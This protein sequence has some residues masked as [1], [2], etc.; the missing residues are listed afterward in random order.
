MDSAGNVYVAE[1]NNHTIRKITPAGLVSTLAGAAGLAN[2]TDGAGAA[3]RFSSPVGVAVDSAGNVYV[4]DAGNNTIRK[5]NSGGVVSTLAGAAR[6]AGI[7]DGP[8]TAARFNGPSSVAVDSAGNLYVADLSNHTLR[9]VTPGGVRV[10]AGSGAFMQANFVTHISP[11]PAGEF[12]QTVSF[13]VGND[14]N[15]FFSVQPA[16]AANGT[17]T[18]TP[19]A[20]KTGTATVTVTAVDSGPGTA[21]SVNTSAP[22]TFLI[23]VAPNAAPSVTFAQQTVAVAQTAGAQTLATFATFSPGPAYE[24]S[25]TNNGY[26]VTVDNPALFTAGGA[27]ALANNGTLTFTPASSQSGSA[28]VTVVVQDNGGTAGGG[29][30]KGTNQF[31]VTVVASPFVATTE[32]QVTTILAP[33]QNSPTILLDRAVVLDSPISIRSI[34]KLYASPRAALRGRFDVGNGGEV[35]LVDSRLPELSIFVGDGGRISGEGEVEEL[36]LQFGATYDSG[37]SPGTITAGSGTWA[38]GA[39]YDWEINN[40]SGAPGT[41]DLFVVNN[42]LTVTATPASRFIVR[43]KSLTAANAPGLLAGFDPQQS[44]AWTIAQAGSVVGFNASAFTV[45]ATGFANPTAGGTFGIRL[46]GGN[47]EVTFTPAPPRL[48]ITR[49]TGNVTVKWADTLA[50]F[51]LEST[52]TPQL[53]ASWAS[54]SG[55]FTFSNGTNS[56]VVPTLPIPSAGARQF[57]RLQGF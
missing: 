22:K 43:V 5:I 14:T 41:T 3:A 20:G 18:F 38:G 53:P 45:D 49:A 2:N 34:L 54:V 56:I 13:T 10:A 27:P 11:G 50:P 4:A 8:G 1:R 35:E 44:Y 25:Q 47:V 16:I 31:T 55:T 51:S 30:D 29:V 9:K 6:Q 33:A 15:A 40:A 42:A 52:A 32:A 24:A 28:T 12:G 48:L 19:A 23:T 37:A 17:L 7:T 39:A 46:N 21:P 26:T 36:T 57:F